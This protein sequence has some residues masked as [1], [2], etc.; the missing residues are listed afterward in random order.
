[1]FLKKFNFNTKNDFEIEMYNKNIKTKNLNIY[2]I[3]NGTCFPIDNIKN[4]NFANSR[5][6]IKV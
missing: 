5:I 6:L 4:L 1:M 3:N 2:K